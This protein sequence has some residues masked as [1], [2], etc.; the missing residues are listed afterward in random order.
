VAIVAHPQFE[1]TIDMEE[2]PPKFEDTLP[3]DE[4]PPK[5]EDTVAADT[6]S[7]FGGRGATSVW[8]QERPTVTN[9]VVPAI[10]FPPVQGISNSPSLDT[11]LKGFD[12]FLSGDRETADK[13]AQEAYRVDPKNIE[14]RN[15]VERL[16]RN[17]TAG[18]HPLNLNRSDPTSPHKS[19]LGETLKGIGDVAKGVYSDIDTSAPVRTLGAGSARLMAQAARIPNLA[20]NIFALPFNVVVDA[21]G[22]RDLAIK[23]PRSFEK[24]ANWWD[25]KANQLSEGV[26]RWGRKGESFVDVLKR[27]DAKEATAYIAYKVLEEAPQQAIVIGS[28]LAGMPTAALSY[29]GVSSAAQAQSGGEKSDASPAAVTTNAII[30]GTLEAALERTP[31]LLGKWS[32]ALTDSF[33]SKGKARILKDV[34][35]TIGASI[36]QEGPVEEGSTEFLQSLAAKATGVNP[37]AMKGVGGRMIEAS[38]IGGAMG[39]G[40]TAPSAI[41][42]GYL[43]SGQDVAPIDAKDKS[44][45]PTQYGPPQG[46]SGT[47][48]DPPPGVSPIRGP[49]VR[50]DVVSPSENVGKGEVTSPEPPSEPEVSG[51]VPPESTRDETPPSPPPPQGTV[52]TQEPFVPPVGPSASTT[53]KKQAYK[54]TKVPDSV[55]ALSGNIQKTT[56]IPILRGVKVENGVGVTTDLTSFVERKVDKPDGVYVV[57]PGKQLESSG[58]KKEDFPVIPERE[59][60]T[61]QGTVD[62]NDLIRNIDRVNMA[63]S[64]DPTRYILNGVLLATKN[65]KTRLIATDGRRMSVSPLDS[66]KLSDGEYI[67]PATAIKNLKGL[68]GDKLEVAINKNNDTITFNTSDSRV[69]MQ[70]IDG[71]YPNYEQIMPKGPHT[72]LSI[73][74]DKLKPVLDAVIAA[75]QEA[76]KLKVV[77]SPRISFLPKGKTIEVSWD[78]V[79]PGDKNEIVNKKVEIPLDSVKT[80]VIDTKL[81]NAG[82]IVMPMQSER[83]PDAQSVGY[84]PTYLNDA[85]N[86]ITSG[87]TWN[88]AVNGDRPNLS[89]AFISGIEPPAFVEETRHGKKRRGPGTKGQASTGGQGLE[90]FEKAT[91]GPSTQ[92][93]GIEKFEKLTPVEQEKGFKLFEQVRGLVKKYAG[94]V[95]ERYLPRGAAGVYYPETKNMRLK[96]LNDLSVAVHEI[97]HA[98]D[99]KVGLSDT[100][101]AKREWDVV[102]GLTEV[103]VEMYPTGNATHPVKKRIVEGLATLIQKTAEMPSAMEFKYGDLVKMFTVPGGKHYVKELDMLLKDTKEIVRKFQQLDRLSQV[104][105][106]VTEHIQQKEARASFLGVRDKIRMEIADAIWPLEKAATVAGIDRTSA[107]P[108]LW[109]RTYQGATGIIINNMTGNRGFWMPTLG[110]NFKKVS[111]Q[112]FSDMIDGLQKRGML[113]RFGWWLLARDTVGD[114]KILDELKVKAIEAAKNVAQAEQMIQEMGPGA[115]MSGGKS[116][117][118]QLQEWKRDIENYEAK[119]GVLSREPLSRNIWEEAYGQN[120]KDFIEDAKLFDAFTAANL[121]L[122]EMAGLATQENLATLRQKEGYAPK[123]RDIYDDILGVE[124]ATMPTVS[125][126][127]TKVS[128]MM[129]RKGSTLTYLNPV[130]S[131]IRDHAEIMKKSLRQMVYNRLRNL[132]STFPDIIQETELKT[133]VDKTTGKIT[134]PQDKDNNIIMARDSS[135]KRHPLLVGKDLKNVIDDVLQFHALNVAENVLRYSARIFSQSTTGMYPPFALMNLAM[136]VPTAIANTRTKMIPFYD[137]LRELRKAWTDKNSV[138]YKYAQEWLASHGER[139][140]LTGWQTLDPMDLYALLHSEKHWITRIAKKGADVADFLSIPGKYSEIFNR[141]TE[142]I[143]SRKV[144]NPWIVA[145]EDSSR[146]TTPFSHMGRWGGGTWLKT[147]NKSVSFFNPSI[148]ALDQFVR[149]AKGKDTQKRVLFVMALTAAASVAGLSYIMKHGTDEQK[150]MYKDLEGKSLTN[151]IWFLNPSGKGLIKVRVPEQYGWLGA[152]INLAMME[153]VF[154][155]DRTFRDYV[156]ATTSWV[157]DQFDVTNPIMALVNSMPQLIKPS[158][159]VAFDTRTFPALRPLT[160]ISQKRLPPSERSIETTSHFAK[161]LGKM[162]NVSPI[163]VD[164]LVEGYF[165]RSTRFLTG[166]FTKMMLNQFAQD[167]YFTSGRNLQDFYETRERFDYLTSTIKNRERKLTKS[168]MIELRHNAPLIKRIDAGL[169]LIRVYEKAGKPLKG[170]ELYENRKRILTDIASLK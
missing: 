110:G 156:D 111:D 154:N 134:F 31:A 84:D 160:P 88:M 117:K 101:N 47:P 15:L 19:G 75:N 108:S 146:V 4:S 66:A 53:K 44:E 165:G 23:S 3:F 65:G 95:G 72:I 142:Y 6:V 16:Q 168:E 113:E 62:R 37:S 20:S 45:Y 83:N 68:S 24:E 158:L 119:K 59:T 30:N 155:T 1:D 40:M 162:L 38:V 157:P 86:S 80:K 150:D 82:S 102:G 81:S 49:G 42:T 33:G 132:S 144:G 112:N 55:P 25:E 151:Y 36:V 48:G 137:S 145:M 130:Y 99:R 28:T 64:N 14:A 17:P 138:E 11:Y 91:E 139:Q 9:G 67:I 58:F 170:D 169:S 161:R 85:L 149:S 133:I 97:T 35:K 159:E 79:I 56:K 96:S 114:Y 73:K 10:Q 147:L 104:G 2:L 118:Q 78:Y 39:A 136:D 27:K 123:K 152:L 167:W 94:I 131:V 129:G 5:F 69:G 143:R 107:D 92:S 50:P 166:R 71:K 125:V 18:T 124:R 60:F 32:K 126:G 120:A 141:L 128:S 153:I 140:S 89:P 51:M 105:T 116:L 103:Y 87:D 8:E 57:T 41:A 115:I 100:L 54:P 74:K 93:I 12:A 109:A 21:V 98:I 22:R 106:F 13:L 164:H 34:A 135:G 61:T 148:Q 52:L 43:Q 163:A 29:M 121:G 127:K 90:S 70:L 77:K 122:I 63:S 26:Q 7:R 76:K 46:D